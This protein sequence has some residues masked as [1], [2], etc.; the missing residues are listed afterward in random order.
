[1]RSAQCRPAAYCP[2]E[3]AALQR[4]SGATES[5]A[6][7][8]LVGSGCLLPMWGV[9]LCAFLWSCSCSNYLIPQD[10][11][12]A[13]VCRVF[14]HGWVALDGIVVRLCLCVYIQTDTRVFK[15]WRDMPPPRPLV[16]WQ[17]LPKGEVKWQV[18]LT[19]RGVV[20]KCHEQRRQE[21]EGSPPKVVPAEHRLNG[22]SHF[23]P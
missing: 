17:Q 21:I 8:R 3:F 20:G 18:H 6:D 4:L 12:H 13:Y 22:W 16:F 23:V 14:L 9:L 19:A 1:M 5:V 15:E 2:A 11:G 10:V 7:L